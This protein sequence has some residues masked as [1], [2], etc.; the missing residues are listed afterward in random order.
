MEF[1]LSIHHHKIVVYHQYRKY[2]YDID[3]APTKH[4]EW[5][6]ALGYILK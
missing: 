2:Y 6:R 1:C 5:L 4:D 3:S